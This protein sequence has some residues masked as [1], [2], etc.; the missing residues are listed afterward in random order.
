MK[1]FSWFLR[2]A[3]GSVLLALTLGSAHRVVGATPEIQSLRVTSVSNGVGLAWGWTGSNS[4]FTV[5]R[6]EAVTEGVWVPAAGIQ[7]WPI[8]A[9]T[10][11][12]PSPATNRAQFYRVVAVPAPQRGRI[13]TNVVQSTLSAAQVGQL[14][15]LA[16]YA[17]TPQY[18]V[19]VR[20]VVYETVDPIGG[21]TTASG[22]LVLPQGAVGALPLFAYQHGT[23]IQTNAAVS[24]TIY[25]EAIVGI[26]FAST[27]YAAA[28]TDYLGLGDSP[29]YHPYIH[30]RTEATAALDLLRASRLFCASNG[31]ALNGQL[32]ICGY[33][34]G[35]HAALAL[36]RELETFHTNEF[37]LTASAPMAGPYDL[38]G[39][40]ATDFLSSRVMPNPYYFA[41]LLKAYQTV[42]QVS[43]SLSNLLQAPYATTLPPLLD[44]AH[45]GSQINAVLPTTPVQILKPDQL[46]AFRTNVTG[47]PLRAALRDNDLLEWTPRAPLRLYHCHADKD[48]LPV[49]STNAFN[50][51]QARGATQVQLI[52]P[53]PT[54]NYDHGGGVLPC[55]SLAKAWFDSLKH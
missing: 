26:A 55:M 23:I 1:T 48:V 15:A 51:F 35:G 45:S 4:A 38:S 29:G 12:D 52:D 21:K 24:S 10:W 17:M 49:N 50:R 53:A 28:L 20:K 32:F 3:G 31:V 14:L 16:G 34:Q 42:Y 25:G 41:Y 27:G 30:A 11:S 46:Q 37:T 13:I 7:P 43:S 47:H 36:H 18:A 54:I 19:V 22:V 5:Q 40:T 2:L 44:G 9:T 6:R 8:T 39:A 33:S